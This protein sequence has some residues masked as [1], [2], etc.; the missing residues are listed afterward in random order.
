MAKIEIVEDNPSIAAV[1]HE[2]LLEGG[3][4]PLLAFAEVAASVAETWQPDVVILDLLMAGKSGEA[5]FHQIRDAPSTAHIPIMITSA[6]SNA[7]AIAHKLGADDVLPKPFS[8][9]TLEERIE[10]ILHAQGGNP[11]P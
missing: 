1:M 6:V 9:A 11:C 2:M 3:H 10:R 5:V 4:E 8:I 7:A